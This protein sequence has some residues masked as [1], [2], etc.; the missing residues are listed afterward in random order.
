MN[1][2]IFLRVFLIVVI[3]LSAL[4]SIHL[5]KKQDPNNKAHRIYALFV[6]TVYTLFIIFQ[7]L[8]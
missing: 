5:M 6:A 7:S 3:W 4:V 8:L 1:K 2:T